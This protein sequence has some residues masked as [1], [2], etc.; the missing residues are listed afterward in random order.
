MEDILLNIDS[1]YRNLQLYPNENK[2]RINLDKPYKNIV[3]AKIV[4][5]EINNTLTYLSD[6]KNNNF[7]KFHLPNK[8]N[9]PEGVILKLP[10]GL[11][12][13]ILSIQ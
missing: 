6:S 12:Q 2:F 8:I 11:Y 5:I 3:S 1:K 4:S 13:S 9:D 10:R 7:I